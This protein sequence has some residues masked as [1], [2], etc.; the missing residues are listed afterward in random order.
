MAVVPP[1]FERP[2]IPAPRSLVQTT[3]VYMTRGTASEV[4][5]YKNC[6]T[7]DTTGSIAADDIFQSGTAPFNSWQDPPTVHLRVTAIFV[8]STADLGNVAVPIPGQKRQW[9]RTNLETLH[10]TSG[11]TKNSYFMIGRPCRIASK[12]AG[13]ETGAMGYWNFLELRIRLRPRGRHAE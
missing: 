3:T 12:S 10:S 9:S 6:I 5:D 2:A 8:S 13:T 1:L 7:T 11:T 4:D